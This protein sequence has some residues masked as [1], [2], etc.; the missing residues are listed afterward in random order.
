M[1]WAPG[2]FVGRKVKPH[3]SLIISFSHLL[4]SFSLGQPYF[5]RFGA[6]GALNLSMVTWCNRM[7]S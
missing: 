1:R 2:L 7:R 6:I 3:I 4:K 5:L